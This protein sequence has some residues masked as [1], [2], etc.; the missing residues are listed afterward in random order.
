MKPV[1]VR[2]KHR[3][4]PRVREGV[5]NAFYRATGAHR[6]GDSPNIFIFTTPRS[7]SNWLLDLIWSQPGFRC[8]DEPLDLRNPLVARALGIPNWDEL[9]AL[10]PAALTELHRYV[11]GLCD[12]QLHTAEP[13]PFCNRFYRYLTRQTVFRIVHGGEDRINWFRDSFNGR[14]VYFIRHPIPVSLSRRAFPRLQTFV[15]SAYA[16]NF[17]DAQLREA[18][19]IMTH[20]SHLERGVLDWC[21]QN[22]LALR[23]T[24]PDWA[25]L[26]YEQLVLE[27]EV[28]VSYLADKL[29]LAD[30]EGALDR[31][32][33]P[34]G[35]SR[36]DTQS[37][38][39][40]E[41]A[42]RKRSRLLGGWRNKVSALQEQQA[43]EILALFDISAY[44]L[45]NLLPAE[46]LWLR[47][48]Y[49]PAGQRLLPLPGSHLERNHLRGPNY[50]PNWRIPAHL[51][52]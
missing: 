25:L 6:P 46:P 40:R 41:N 14:I 15:N 34:A 35:V 20:G 22:A 4:P 28:S 30:A 43:L 32:G 8:V 16:D 5:Y 47:D 27:P 29:E 51:P 18:Q 42:A 12:G 49:D 7:S 38:R 24:T 39:L 31:L 50:R 17:S 1:L 23:Q 11:Q 33:D 21:F 19:R 52:K 26:S 48:S 3:T 45:G 36:S 44:K 2:L 9:A 10:P 37:Q 13:D